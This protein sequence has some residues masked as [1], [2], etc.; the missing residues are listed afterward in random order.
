MADEII[1]VLGR[2]ATQVEASVHA[3]Y[4]GEVRSETAKSRSGIFVREAAELIR[5]QVVAGG[6]AASPPPASAPRTS[7]AAPLAPGATV[8]WT[9]DEGEAVM[10]CVTAWL[11]M[12]APS[13]AMP[14]SKCIAAG[15]EMTPTWGQRETAR[16]ALR[17][18]TSA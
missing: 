8:G 10:R 16:A 13:T 15:R 4:R 9:R 11:P 17:K 5:A 12:G 1:D 18:L 14:E 6:G 2:L 7:S 3:L